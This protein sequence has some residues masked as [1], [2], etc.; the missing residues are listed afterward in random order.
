MLRR[1]FGAFSGP[2]KRAIGD[3]AAGLTGTAAVV[4]TA[5][6]DEPAGAPPAVATLLAADVASPTILPGAAGRRRRTPDRGAGEERRALRRWRLVLGG[7]DAGAGSGLADAQLSDEDSGD[8]RGAGRPLRQAGRGGGGRP[9][10]REPGR[11]GA[12]GRALAGRHPHATSR[13]PSCR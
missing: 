12:A 6:A 11:V 2:E 13:A 10:G 3:R 7:E 5:E 4:A 9:R 1:T 8:G